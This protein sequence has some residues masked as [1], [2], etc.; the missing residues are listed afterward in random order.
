MSVLEA[1]RALSDEVTS[2]AAETEA[3]RCVPADL[4]R[5][6]GDT[7]AFRLFVPTAL[8]G[9]EADPLTACTVVEEVSRA[10]GSTGWTTMIL[11]TTFFSCWLEHDVAREMLATDPQLGMA[12]TFGPI[13]RARATGNGQVTL[14]GRFPFNSGSPHATWFCQGA[15]LEDGASQPSW[16][17]VFVP[18]A[19]VVIDDTWYVAGLRGTASHDVVIDEATVPRE[20]I[21][22]PIFQRSPRDEPH[23]RW[24]FFNLLSALIA[25]FPIGVARRAL[26]EFIA[27]AQRAGRAGGPPMAADPLVQLEVA[28]CD[29]AWR[30]ARAGLHDALGEAWDCAVAGD[31]TTRQHRLAVRLAANHAMQA[32]TTVVDSMFALAGGKAIYDSSP[33]QRCWR[34]VHAG[35]AHIFFS[36][37]PWTVGGSLLMGQEVEDWAL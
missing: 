10:D 34:D 24:S 23:F 30:A 27:L 4:A 14:S 15:M 2:R 1:V 26:D 21:T 35:D 7:G 9:V 16:Q 18:R 19:E 8:D 29:A 17:F 12:G 33:L 22:N 32:S 37:H 20:R 11:N 28:R 25:G 13:G 31:D 6:I 36:N 5:R 3:E